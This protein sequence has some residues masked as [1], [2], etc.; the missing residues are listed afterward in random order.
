MGGH[1][2]RTSIVSNCPECRGIRTVFFGVCDVCFAEL[3]EWRAA[4]LEPV[5]TG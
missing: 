2:L 5:A 1:D 3:D 4:D